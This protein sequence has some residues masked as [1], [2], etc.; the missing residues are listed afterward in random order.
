MRRCSLLDALKVVI[1]PV[2]L[3]ILIRAAAAK[4]VDSISG[5]IPVVS[6]IAIIA[7]ITIVV[8]LNAQS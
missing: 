1:V 6:V 7:I 5:I 3:G 2:I 8:A 4:T